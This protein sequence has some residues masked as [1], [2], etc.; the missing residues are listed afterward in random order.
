MSWKQKY[1]A[2]KVDLNVSVNR[3]ESVTQ[4]LNL[5]INKSK[6]AALRVLFYSNRYFCP[7][8]QNGRVQLTILKE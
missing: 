3:I 7:N 1:L 2:N 8:I 5:E 6:H 4:G